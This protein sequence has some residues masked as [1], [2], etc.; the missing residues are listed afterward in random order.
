M[1]LVRCF[2]VAIRVPFS[3]LDYALIVGDIGGRMGGSGWNGPF[4]NRVLS[5]C[6]GLIHPENTF[7]FLEFC[8]WYILIIITKQYYCRYSL[9]SGLELVTINFKFSD[10]GVSM[11]RTRMWFCLLVTV[12]QVCFPTHKLRARYLGWIN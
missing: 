2:Y 12:T 7:S 4:F 3:S 5:S 11:F 9:S 1:T 10:E 6:A 8:K